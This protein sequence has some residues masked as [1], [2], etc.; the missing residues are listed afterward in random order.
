VA[1]ILAQAGVRN[2]REGQKEITGSCPM[3]KERVGRAD[4]HASWSMNRHTFVHHCFSCGYSGTLSMLLTDLQG[5]APDDIETMVREATVGTNMRKLAERAEA[6]APERR[7]ATEWELT[8]TLTDMPDRLLELRHLRREAVDA[9]GVRWD[10]TTK[11][12]VLPIRDPNGVLLGA[13]Y[14]QKGNVLNLPEGLEKSVTLFGF[15]EMRQYN[16]VAL[17]ESPLDAVRLFGL[18]IPA[19]SSFGAWVSPTQVELLARNFT[20]V[21][22]MLDNDKAGKEATAHTAEALRRRRCVPIPFSYRGLDAKDPGDVEDDSM[23]LANWQWSL[24]NPR[25]IAPPPKKVRT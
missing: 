17:V 18:G 1:S 9:Y 25:L 7:A 8:H 4:A 3:H 22:M 16:R 19:V 21:V 10:K 11:S 23:L 6:K 15:S 24:T 12:W 5:Y 20:S 14:R 13:Q 2:I